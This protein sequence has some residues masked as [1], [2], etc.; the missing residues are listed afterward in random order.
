MKSTLLTK[1]NI[2]AIVRELSFNGYKVTKDNGT[3]KVTD[4]KTQQDVLLALG[5]TTGKNW[6]VRYDEKLMEKES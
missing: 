4:R 3:I 5:H 1:T 6:L 2:N